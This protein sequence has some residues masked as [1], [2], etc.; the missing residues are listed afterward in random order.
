MPIDDLPAEVARS[1]GLFLTAVDELSPGLITGF[2]LVGSVALDDFHARGAGRGRLTTASD[3]DFVAVTDQRVE[4]DSPEMAALAEAHGRTVRAAPRPNFDGAVLNWM[5]LAAGPLECPDV[6]CAQE[7]RFT[8]CGRSGI[9]PVTFCELAWHGITVRGPQPGDT[10]VWA[11]RTALRDFTVDNLH[12]YWRSWWE[13]SRRAHPRS[14]AVG[15]TPWFPVW[16][17]LGV[18]RLHH[19]LATGTMASKCG[20]GRHALQT[21]DPHWQPIIAESL[22]LRTDGAEGCRSYRNPLARRRDTLAFLDAAIDSAL[23]LPAIL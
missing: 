12:S 14:L 5:D 7:S 6:P 19:V 4:P 15:L 8:A 18:S 21:F 3:I 20:A 23:A 9:N 17:V 22:H 16:A 1:V 13:R 10:E 11:D 2:Y